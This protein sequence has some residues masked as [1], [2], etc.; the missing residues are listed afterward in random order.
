MSG[1]KVEAKR[2]HDR[3]SVAR[4]APVGGALSSGNA[5]RHG[6]CAEHVLPREKKAAEFERLRRHI[7]G[8]SP[9]GRAGGGLGGARRDDRLADETLSAAEGGAV[10]VDDEGD[11]VAAGLV[12]ATGQ[13]RLGSGFRG[14]R[15]RAGAAEAARVRQRAVAAVAARVASTPNTEIARQR[16]AFRRPARQT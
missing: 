8:P 5:I 9:D 3:E 2:L 10:R 4:R 7:D 11:G 13:S 14:H 15:V 6:L 12:G 1:A 16:A